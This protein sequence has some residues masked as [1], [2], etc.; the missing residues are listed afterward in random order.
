MLLNLLIRRSRMTWLA[1][2]ILSVLSDPS[3]GYH[4]FESSLEVPHDLRSTQDAKLLEIGQASKLQSAAKS[5]ASIKIISYNIRWRGGAQL[6]QLIELLK[7]DQEIG[8]ATIIGLQEVDRNKKRTANENTVKLI[9]ET[10]GCYY[11]WTAPPPTKEGQ[12][13]ETGVA[14]LSPYPLA[15]IHRIILPHKG[16]GGRQRIA[17]GATVAVADTR[18]RVY[19][20]HSENRMSVGRKIEQTKAVLADLAEYSKVMPAIIL[21]DLNTWEPD[22]VDKTSKLFPSENFSTPFD[23]GQTTFL[24]RVLMIP[25]KLK[26]DWIWLRGLEATSHGIDKQIHL[27]DHWPLWV[28]VKESGLREREYV[29]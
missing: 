26:L 25:I 27:S 4:N 21:G 29:P 23:H 15:D 19:S 2:L 13:E 6:R 16:P 18:I 28:V 1:I 7:H 22:A 17:L 3:V 14:I 11:A 10:L 8:G 24:R 12:E 9:A 5:P 20:V